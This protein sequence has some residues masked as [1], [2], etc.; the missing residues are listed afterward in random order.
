MVVVALLLLIACVNVANLLLAR[1]AGRRREFG[2]RRALGAS[3]LRLVRQ[4]LAEG[5]LLSSAGVV[6]G[7]LCGLWTSQ[8]LMQQ[9]SL[10]FMM[11]GAPLNV[12]LDLSLDWRLLLF[13]SALGVITTV[14]FATAPAWAASRVDPN[15]SLAEQR[16]GLV[17]GG[18]R[19]SG[20][21]L[22]LVQV[23][24]SLVLLVA[25]GLFI[26]SFYGLATLRLGFEPTRVLVVAIDSTFGMGS[27]RGFQNLEPTNATARFDRFRAAV[28][29][30]PGVAHAA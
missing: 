4:L 6:L 17:V 26:R 16:R 22:V 18:R 8:L 27:G 12:V 30:V 29:V 23:A 10:E 19:D 21:T 15:R 5:V 1:A 2:I 14:L 20:H 7:L 13:A 28:A 3:R 11:G 25:C 9:L 24:L